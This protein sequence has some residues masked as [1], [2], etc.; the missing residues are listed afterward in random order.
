[1][2]VFSLLYGSGQKTSIIDKDMARP[3]NIYELKFI[4]TL[5]ENVLICNLEKLLVPIM[6]NVST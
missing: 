3:K 6:K 4:S 2:W 1:M 5:K